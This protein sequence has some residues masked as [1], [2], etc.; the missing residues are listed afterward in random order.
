MDEPTPTVKKKRK[1]TRKAKA[2]LIVDGKT[3]R[4]ESVRHENHFVVLKT[5]K[6]EIRVNSNLAKV[7]EITQPTQ[8]GV[9]PTMPTSPQVSAD[10]FR[11]RRNA[12]L[13]GLLQMPD[14]RENG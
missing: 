3:Y 8:H 14:L 6:G 4:G 11:K 7:V 1:Y 10:I 9:E 5:A 12:E 13:N 2:V